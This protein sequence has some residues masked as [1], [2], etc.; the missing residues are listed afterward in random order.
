MWQ[1]MP[2]FAWAAPGVP[3][4]PVKGDAGFTAT[5]G[6]PMATGAD[7]AGPSSSSAPYPNVYGSSAAPLGESAQ[8][9]ELGAQ[10]SSHFQGIPQPV[11]N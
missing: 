5:T 7:G 10:S 1:V 3:V 2:S 4:P 9:L 6:F 8:L 11:K